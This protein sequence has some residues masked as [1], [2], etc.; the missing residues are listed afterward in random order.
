MTQRKKRLQAGLKVRD[1]L[2]LRGGGG[3]SDSFAGLG[4]NTI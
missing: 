4:L 1:L 3:G 2:F